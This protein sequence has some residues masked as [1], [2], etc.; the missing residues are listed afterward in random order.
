MEEFSIY[1]LQDIFSCTCENWKSNLVAGLKI[2]R[3]KIPGLIIA[4]VKISREKILVSDKEYGVML[5]N[6]ALLSYQ[7]PLNLILMRKLC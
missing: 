3:V 6:E 1:K 2:G 4:R 7:E 5:I